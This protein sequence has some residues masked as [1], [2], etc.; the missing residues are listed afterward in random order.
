MRE[1]DELNVQAQ[2]ITNYCNGTGELIY[3]MS[4]LVDAVRGRVARATSTLSSSQV[5]E[6]FKTDHIV[7]AWRINNMMLGYAQLELKSMSDPKSCKF[8]KWYDSAENDPFRNNMTFIEIG[9]HHADLHKFG[10][11][12]IIAYQNND[13]VKAEKHYKEMVNH[14]NKMLQAFSTLNKVFV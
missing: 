4:R 7:Y 14:L 12:T 9:E 3:N 2:N 10:A 5:L 11:Q 13:R 1:V 6:M 8:G